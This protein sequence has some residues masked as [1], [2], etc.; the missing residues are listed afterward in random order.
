[1]NERY[2]RNK[3]VMCYSVF[4]LIHIIQVCTLT[5]VNVHVKKWVTHARMKVSLSTWFKHGISAH[6][7]VL[8]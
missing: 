7:V 3:L 2:F 6:A 5:Q 4:S 8:N 1:M